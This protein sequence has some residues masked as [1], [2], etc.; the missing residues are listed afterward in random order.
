[1]IVATLLVA[2][3]NFASPSASTLPQITPQGV[4]AKPPA[5]V[6][7]TAPIRGS[8]PVSGGTPEP[9]SMLLLVGGALGYGA[10]RLRRAR[11]ESSAK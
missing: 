9:A 11:S 3:L 8:M 2:G 7:P 6:I 4:P 1:M 5:P 10:H